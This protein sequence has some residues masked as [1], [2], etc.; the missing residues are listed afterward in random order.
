MKSKLGIISSLVIL[1]G[2]FLLFG[3]ARNKSEKNCVKIELSSMKVMFFGVDNPISITAPGIDLNTLEVTAKGGKIRKDSTSQGKYYIQPEKAWRNLIVDVKLKKGISLETICSDTFRCKSIQNPE[4]Y[5]G[6]HCRDCSMN[7]TE[8]H[9]E[10]GVFARMQDC[11]FN[12][13]F[14]ITSFSMSLFTNGAWQESTTDG[15]AFSEMQ[16][17][18]L[19]KLN[20][21]DR[22]LFHHVK[23]KGYEP[24]DSTIV[25]SISGMYITVQ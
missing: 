14:R 3:F 9:K 7:I 18:D 19:A 4:F 2:L 5:F 21:G 22:I 15:P 17:N 12:G 20:S 24:F 13:R 1:L 23:V 11:D 25:R 6:V 16:I 8:I 10:L